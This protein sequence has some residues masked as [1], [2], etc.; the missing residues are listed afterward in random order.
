M[1]QFEAVDMALSSFPEERARYLLEKLDASAI[2][3]LK[4]NAPVRTTQNLPNVNIRKGA[5]GKVIRYMNV[6]EAEKAGHLV[7]PNDTPNLDFKSIN[8][9]TFT[10]DDR[11]PLVRFSEHQVVLCVPVPSTPW[12]PGGITQVVRKQIPL[13]LAFA[14][15]IHSSQAKMF[16][17]VKVDC[18]GMFAYG[19]PLSRVKGKD[20]VELLDLHLLR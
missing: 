9:H 3:K 17:R 13:A 5:V 6:R 18:N 20:H 16:S 15:T 8:R 1:A 7:V 4:I 19:Q 14:M 12:Q 2:V 10:A 11:W